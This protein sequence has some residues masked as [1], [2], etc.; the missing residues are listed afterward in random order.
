MIY[1]SLIF[2]TIT[3]LLKT[4]KILLDFHEDVF[5]EENKFEVVYA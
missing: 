1:I 5:D 2:I 4:V 3:L